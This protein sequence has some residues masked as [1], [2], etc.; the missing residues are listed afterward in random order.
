M[1]VQRVGPGLLRAADLG[2]VGGVLRFAAPT[3]WLVA[4]T[5]SV[6]GTFALAIALVTRIDPAQAAAHQVCM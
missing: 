5:A 3:A 1:L 4:R 6:G 2:G